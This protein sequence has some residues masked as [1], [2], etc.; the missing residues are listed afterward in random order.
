MEE[1]VVRV[2]A[3]IKQWRGEAGLSL[4]E[5]AN[6]SDVSP[7]TI[8][9][10]EHCQTVPTIA[11][12]LK[13]AAGLGRHPTELFEDADQSSSTFLIRADKRRELT[14]PQGARI[15]ELAGDPATRDLGMWRVEHPPG[16][17][18][19]KRTMNHVS[20][21]VV[22]YIETGELQVRVGDEDFSLDT[23]DTLHFKASSPYSWQNVSDE[24]TVA[25]ILGN[26]SDAIR[27][28][29]V[30]QMGRFGSSEPRPVAELATRAPLRQGTPV[31]A[32]G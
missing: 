2:A 1:S 25:V 24:S 28:A 7:S 17:S 26:T 18:F 23:G 29:L 11:V 9:K 16:F 8:H 13:L 20:G 14:T 22:L 31:A 5:L 21:E 3:R 6:R 15:Q 12:V 10:I 30:A 32:R 27:P 4:Q 19:S